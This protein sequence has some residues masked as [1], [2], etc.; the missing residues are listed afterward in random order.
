MHKF[1]LKICPVLNGYGYLVELIHF[2]GS[3]ESEKMI[4]YSY[5]KAKL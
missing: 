3:L 4:N 5:M 2:L 1:Q